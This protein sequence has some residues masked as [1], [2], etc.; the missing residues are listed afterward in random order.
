MQAFHDAAVFGLIAL[1]PPSVVDTCCRRDHHEAN[2]RGFLGLPDDKPR[3][4]RTLLVVAFLGVVVF[5]TAVMLLAVS[6]SHAAPL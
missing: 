2:A 5:G 6:T 3:S 4:M 1:P